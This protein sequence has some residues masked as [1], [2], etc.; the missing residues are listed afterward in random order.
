MSARHPVEPGKEVGK[1]EMD[2]VVDAEKLELPPSPYEKKEMPYNKILATGLG[3]CKPGRVKV[4]L[5]IQRIP[6]VAGKMCMVLW[7]TRAQ[8]LLV[9][10]QCGKEAGFKGRTASIQISG[11]GSGNNKKSKV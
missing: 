7:D 2:T 8:I 10:H 9:T 11:V 4:Q 5:M 3:R 6:D 1:G